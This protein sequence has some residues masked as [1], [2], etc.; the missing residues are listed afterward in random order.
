MPESLCLFVVFHTQ[1]AE[2]DR[3]GLK[4]AEGSWEL[5]GWAGGA[6][7]VKAPLGTV[8]DPM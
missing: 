8:T 2:T 4:E 5:S 3:A 7:A 1:A 6:L